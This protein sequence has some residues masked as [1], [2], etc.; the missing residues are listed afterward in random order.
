MG[1]RWILAATAVAALAAA[2]PAVAAGGA[3][4]SSEATR[5]E[6]REKKTDLQKAEERLGRENYKGA[7]KYLKRHLDDNPDSADGWN[8]MGY[9]HR[10]QQKYAEAEEHYDRALEL[11]PDH[12]GALEYRGELYLETGRPDEARRALDRLQTLCPLGCDELNDM[13][14]AFER[15]G[16]PVEE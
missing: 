9:A 13:K 11:D 5:S 16:V 7:V 3:Y 6:P 15:L 2:Q 8:L 14:A 1:K 12:R 4:G 10:K